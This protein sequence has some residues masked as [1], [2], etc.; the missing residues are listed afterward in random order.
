MGTYAI[1]GAASGIGAATRKKLENDGH[2]VIGIDLHETEVVADLATPE[3]RRSAVAGTL[4]RCSGRLDGLVTAAG[5]GPPVPGPLVT[6]VNYFGS[7]S[8]LEGLQPALAAAGAAQVVQVGSNSTT[9]TPNVP[10]DLIDAFLAGDEDEALRIVA[11]TRAPFDSSVAYAGSKL[12]ITRWCRRAAVRD[13]WVGRGI[14]LNV[15]APGPVRTP[16]FQAGLEDEDYGPL[17]EGFPIP[18]GEPTT[19]ELIADWIVFLLSPPAR[20]ACGSV[21]YVDGGADATLR[22]DDW[23]AT[24]RMEF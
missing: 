4:E 6:K 12:A 11:L 17:M 14:I 22:A 2:R 8:L 19:P 9:T 20:F 18:T 3:G 24:L 7:H 16:L 13:D 10:D 15:I 5:V 1:S 21:V 23:P